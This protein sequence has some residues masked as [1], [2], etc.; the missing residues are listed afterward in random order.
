MKIQVEVSQ[1]ILAAVM[2]GKCVEGRL[3]LQLSSMGTHQEVGFIP[4]NRKPRG[5]QDRVICQLE[6]GWLKESP[7]RY[8]FFNSV[9]KDLDLLT[10]DRV[11]ARELKTAMTALMGDKLMELIMNEVND[12]L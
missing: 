10:V 11:M 8:K 7:K 5:S 9:K 1:Q 3:R 12:N 6:N 2:D 4:Y